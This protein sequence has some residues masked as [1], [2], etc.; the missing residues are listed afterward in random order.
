MSGAVSYFHTGIFLK[1]EATDD[2]CANADHRVCGYEIVTPNVPF[3]IDS[4]GSISITQTLTND[5]YEFDVIAIDCYPASDNSRKVSQPARVTFK[6]IKDCKPII[7][8]KKP[9]VV[10]RARASPYLQTV[11]HRN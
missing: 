3:S 5:Q 8:G 7:T 2:D 9:S 4:Q 1:V 11:L 6:L 10:E